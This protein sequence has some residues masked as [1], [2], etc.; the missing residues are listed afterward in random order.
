[1]QRLLL[2]EDDPA[3]QFTIQTALEE[4]GYAVDAVSTTGEAIERLG[5]SSLPDRHFRYLHRRAHRPGRAE[6]RQTART[7][8][9]L[10]DPDDG[11][12]HRGN[13]DGGHARRRL[14]L[15]R[16]A[17][18]PGCADSTPSSAPKPRATSEEDE[19][20]RGGTAGD[21][22]DRHFAGDGGDLQDCFAR[23]PTPTPR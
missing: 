23:P 5:G 1:M 10:G 6:R 2:V 13:R 20:E 19:A 18:R 11:P 16:Q 15:H 9:V 8:T 21:R 17:V 14:R 22:N 4:K 3:L 12:R 7:R